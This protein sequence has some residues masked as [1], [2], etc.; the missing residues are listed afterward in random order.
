MKQVISVRDLEE[1]VRHGRDIRSRCPTDALLTP[2]ARDF[3]R[4]LEDGVGNGNAAAAAPSR[5]ATNGAPAKACHVQELARRSWKRFSTR[6]RCRSYKEAICEIGRRLWQRAYVDGNGGN[7]AIRRRR[8]GSGALHADADF[9]GLH[10]ARGHVPGGPGRQPVGRRQEADQRNPDAPADDE[11]PAEGAGVGAL[12]SAARD[13]LC[14]GGSRAADLH[15][16]GISKCF[17][18]WPSRRIARRARR[19]WASWWRTWW[20]STTPF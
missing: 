14:R 5:Q 19:R 3:L 8:E 4:D 20:T 9:Q 6:R 10:E 11:A 18:R 2:S 17:A 15:D 13:G 16:P 7:I 12:S 1:M